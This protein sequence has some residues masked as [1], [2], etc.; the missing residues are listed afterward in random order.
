MSLKKDLLGI[1]A[2]FSILNGIVAFHDTKTISDMK[3]SLSKEHRIDTTL[4]QDIKPS[5]INPVKNE[6]L[7]RQI[8]RI[9]DSAIL[10]RCNPDL[11]DSAIST[12]VGKMPSHTIPTTYLCRYVLRI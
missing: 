4:L 5:I 3:N 6:R 10:S 11:P 12:M 7:K 9:G 8:C 2:I 1:G